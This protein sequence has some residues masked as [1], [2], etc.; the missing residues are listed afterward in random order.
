[1]GTFKIQSREPTIYGLRQTKLVP[2]QSDII[3]SQEKED[4]L[5]I[6]SIKRELQGGRGW[7]SRDNSEIKFNNGFT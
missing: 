4:G 1:M 3:V 7:D 2:P 6:R 5:Q